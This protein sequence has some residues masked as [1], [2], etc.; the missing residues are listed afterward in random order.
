MYITFV[1]SICEKF[2]LQNL[3]NKDNLIKILN[4]KKDEG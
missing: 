4:M 2:H 1:I 3:D